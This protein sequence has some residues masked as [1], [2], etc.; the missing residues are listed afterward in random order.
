MEHEP[1]EKIGHHVA[2]PDSLDIYP[3]TASHPAKI[4]T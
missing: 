4:T 3:T 2:E 1:A